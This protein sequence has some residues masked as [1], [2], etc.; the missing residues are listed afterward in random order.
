MV[1]GV[2]GKIPVVR[3]ERCYTEL[4]I[5]VILTVK[6]F[7]GIGSSGRDVRSTPTYPAYHLTRIRFARMLRDAAG[8]P[9]VSNIVP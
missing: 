9:D 3:R 6:S 8:L 2:I 7:A 1:N 5:S 4:Y